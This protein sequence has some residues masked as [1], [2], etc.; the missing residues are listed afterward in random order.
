MTSGGIV[1]SSITIRC[2]IGGLKWNSDNCSK[3]LSPN[4]DTMLQCMLLAYVHK[5][6][7]CCDTSLLHLYTQHYIEVN[8]TRAC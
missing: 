1:F 2:L 4:N 6:A 7:K 3:I 5:N 8:R